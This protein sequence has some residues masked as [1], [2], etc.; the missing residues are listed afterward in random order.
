[1][2]KLLVWALLPLSLAL[3]YSCEDHEK[4][5]LQAEVTRLQEKLDKANLVAGEFAIVCDTPATDTI[6]KYAVSEY[7]FALSPQAGD[8][9]F[10]VIKMDSMHTKSGF[11]ST[12]R[13]HLEGVNLKMNQAGDT[14]LVWLCQDQAAPLP[15]YRATAMYREI[16]FITKLQY[17]DALD[18]YVV[19]Y[20]D[21]SVTPPVSKYDTVHPLN[22]IMIRDLDADV[23][24]VIG[25]ADYLNDDATIME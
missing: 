1:M 4:A 6:Y 11:T 12:T 16:T 9:Y 25:I 18:R 24:P 19:T 2:K 5:K 23:K 21:T 7:H 15:Q 22:I 8:G 3:I 14:L 20:R 13:M 17:D 10:H